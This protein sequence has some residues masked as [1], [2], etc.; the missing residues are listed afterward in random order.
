MKGNERK[1]VLKS[2]INKKNCELRRRNEMRGNEN[3][4]KKLIREERIKCIKL[5]EKKIKIR[6]E[7][8]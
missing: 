5:R 3:K 2:V 8:I 4:L 6:K 1:E 7:I